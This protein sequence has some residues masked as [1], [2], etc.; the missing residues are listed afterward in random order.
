MLINLAIFFGAGFLIMKAADLF[1][2]GA[3]EISEGLNLPKIL[4]AATIV[5]LVTTL[6]ELIVSVSS[7]YLGQT[8][9]AVGN[10]VGSCVCNV[11]LVLAVGAII[12]AIP[13]ER[14]DFIQRVAILLGS[15]I[16]V[17]MLAFDGTIGRADAII[18]LIGLGFYLSFNYRQARQKRQEII[19]FAGVGE[20]KANLPRGILLFFGGGI[21]IIILA[22][23]GLVETGLNIANIL[24][25]PPIVIGL[26]LTAL[27]TSL[28][29]LFTTIASSRRRH[30]EISLGNVIGSNVLN[31]L[32]VLGFAALVRPLSIDRQTVLF[33][34]P[35]AILVTAILLLFGLNGRAL[36]RKIGYILLGLYVA[37]ISGLYLFIYR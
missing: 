21:A 36:G 1:I 3:V 29:E 32:W 31:L 14:Q 8:G 35:A 2:N 25:I 13:I 26:S 18:L 15:Y 23:F 7:S 5:S 27:G 37:Y 4:I 19:A 33:N 16:L 30:S 34:L 12:R 10:A 17:Y 28:P 6:P 11:G 24:N 20:A 9:M 22:R